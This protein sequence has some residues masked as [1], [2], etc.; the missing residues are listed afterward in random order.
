MSAQGVG[1]PDITIVGAG[2]VGRLLG[3][4]LSGARGVGL[5]LRLV[6]AAPVPG[7]PGDTRA[8][9]IAAGTVRML[10]KLG[11]WHRLEGK[12]QACSGMRITD[13][14]AAELVRPAFLTIAGDAR[15][16]E[17]FAHFVDGRDLQRAIIEACDAAGLEIEHDVAVSGIETDTYGVSLSGDES[18]SR[19]LV[20]ADG[21]KSAVRKAAGIKTVGWSYDQGAIITVIET[22]VPHEGEA[23]QHFLPGGPFAM[24]PLPGNGRGPDNKRGVVWTEKTRDAERLCRLGEERFAAEMIQRAGPE[25]GEITVIEPPRVYPLDLTLARGFVAPRIAL[26]GDAAHRLHPLAGLGLNMG[27]RDVAALA[28]VIAE[29]ARRGEDFGSLTVLER[30]QRW[31]RFD[32]VQVAAATEAI[33]RLFSN[34]LG[35]LR[36]V[37]DVGLGLVDRMGPLKKIFVSEAAGDAGGAPRLLRGEPV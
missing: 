10:E 27:L 37:R 21:A 31:R 33:N 23:I 13:S 29:A 22:E 9:A 19:L 17:P 5:T 14:R 7:R 18:P 15:D 35:P 3:L 6:D 11:I 26:I 24:L 34:D 25:V 20:G 8:Y 4:A 32:T 36:A 16:G 12:T 2:Y 1:T 30:Y 28:E